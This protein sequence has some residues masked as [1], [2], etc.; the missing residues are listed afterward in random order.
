[1]LPTIRLKTRR[2]ASGRYAILW[3]GGDTGLLVQKGSPPKYHQPQLWSLGQPFRDGTGIYWLSDD[4]RSKAHALELI[5][6]IATALLGD[7]K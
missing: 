5:K 3:N 6:V 2:R 1:M 7:S 4:L